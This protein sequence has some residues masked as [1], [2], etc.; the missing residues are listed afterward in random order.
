[1]HDVF[2]GVH[3]AVPEVLPRRRRL[4]LHPEECIFR[5]AARERLGEFSSAIVIVTGV[6]SA[7]VMVEHAQIT[8]RAE[9]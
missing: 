1:M 8:K 4:F 5:D 6:A 2:E 3:G 7:R 9:V